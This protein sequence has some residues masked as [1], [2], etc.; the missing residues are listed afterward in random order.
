MLLASGVRGVR[1]TG[2]VDPVAAMTGLRNSN[3]GAVA[4]PRVAIRAYI[5]YNGCMQCFCM[6]WLFRLYRWLL[7]V[8]PE[9][10]GTQ[11]E[12]GVHYTGP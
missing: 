3:S 11:H 6:G 12:E 10:E 1:G 4:N 5:M 9:L 7:V 8:A 2:P